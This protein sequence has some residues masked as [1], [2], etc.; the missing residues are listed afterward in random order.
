MSRGDGVALKAGGKKTED[1][2]LRFYR[3]R[4]RVYGGLLIFVIAAGVP[5]ATVPS[6]RN[7][8]VT[9]I[10][11]LKAAISGE[12]RLDIVQAGEN[13][14]RFPAEYERPSPPSVAQVFK[15]ATAPVPEDVQKKESPPARSVPRRTLRIPSV[16]KPSLSADAGEES[17][18]QRELA[19]SADTEN[20]PKYKQ[21]TMEQE[22]YDL[23]LKSNSAIAGL[24]QG[25]NP[26]LQFAAWDAAGRGE[27]IYWV[28]L[29]FRQ[30]GKPG[31]E[32]I[33]Q[34]QLQSKQITP[35]NYNARAL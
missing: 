21:G 27:D 32:Y 7:R 29:K 23:L 2:S 14:E 19:P 33:W 26:S 4:R 31:I 22:A 6:L 10:H 9:R 16:G 35:L 25:G 13:T 5:I 8:L 24:V 18:E 28:R 20:Q 30:E 11:D 17:G 15:I 34:V 12:T 1:G 3:I